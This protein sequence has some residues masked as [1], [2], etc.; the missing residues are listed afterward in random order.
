MQHH[1]SLCDFAGENSLNH[2]IFE[3]YGL[4]RNL[5]KNPIIS[6]S[7]KVLRMISDHGLVMSL[8]NV[9]IMLTIALLDLPQC[10]EKID[11]DLT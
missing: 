6:V 9:V 11:A 3:K 2:Q 7:D 4:K 1:I 10:L 8:Y 5:I